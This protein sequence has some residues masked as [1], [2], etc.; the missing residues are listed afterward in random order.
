MNW[1]PLYTNKQN[2]VIYMYLHIKKTTT[3]LE[4]LNRMVIKQRNTEQTS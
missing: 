1:T 2:N 4:N 3:V